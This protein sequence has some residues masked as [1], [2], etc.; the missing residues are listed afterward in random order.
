MGRLW[1]REI[2]GKVRY[3]ISRFLLSSGCFQCCN[4]P[5]YLFTEGIRC[6]DTG[7]LFCNDTVI[8]CREEILVMPVKLTYQAF[9]PVTCNSDP[10]FSAD[11]NPEPWV[12]YIVRQAEE[13]K[14][15]CVVFSPACRHPKKLP[16]FAETVSL[17]KPLRMGSILSQCLRQGACAPLHG[18]A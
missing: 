18:A 16:P 15:R 4:S 13:D 10:Y 17:G 9:N 8:S 2:S 14:M 12:P 5:R 3:L 1:G 11:R 6:Y 7:P